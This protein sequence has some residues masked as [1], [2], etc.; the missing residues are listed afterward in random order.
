MIQ[1]CFKR[2]PPSP[3][4]HHIAGTKL[5]V[6]NKPKLLGLTVLSDFFLGLAGQQHGIKMHFKNGRDVT[7]YFIYGRSELRTVQ[8]CSCCQ[9]P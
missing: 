3:R 7:V 6:V 8:L 1:I 4:D 9:C 2:Q 5:E